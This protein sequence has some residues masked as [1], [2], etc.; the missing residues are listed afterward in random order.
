M[1]WHFRVSKISSN[2]VFESSAPRFGV[3]MVDVSSGGRTEPQRSEAVVVVE[4]DCDAGMVTFAEAKYYVNI[5]AGL[6]RNSSVNLRSLASIPLLEVFSFLI[7]SHQIPWDSD[8]ASVKCE[9]FD[10]IALSVESVM[11]SSHEKQLQ[12]LMG[13]AAMETSPAEFVVAILQRMHDM[14]ATLSMVVKIAHLL[15][16]YKGCFNNKLRSLL[17]KSFKDLFS[18]S[19]IITHDV[20]SHWEIPSDSLMSYGNRTLKKYEGIVFEL[21]SGNCEG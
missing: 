4:D 18:S 9:I 2:D 17:S 14:R 11:G 20:R 1:F 10:S 21:M 6:I 5:F 19:A 12:T 13:D 3:K 7:R 15:H 16:V 8:V